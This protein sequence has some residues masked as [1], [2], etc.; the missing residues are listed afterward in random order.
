MQQPYT[1]S[2]VPQSKGS[3]ALQAP[4]VKKKPKV[5]EDPFQQFDNLYSGAGASSTATATSKAMPS[6]PLKFEMPERAEAGSNPF[7]GL[8]GAEGARGTRPPEQQRE[9]QQRTAE[10]LDRG[11]SGGNMAWNDPH[12]P[13]SGWNPRYAPEQAAQ[14]ARREQDHGGLAAPI[15]EK[16]P[17]WEP[18]DPIPSD[19]PSDGP[20]KWRPG[21]PIPPE[22][23]NPPEGGWKHDPDTGYP[24]DQ[25]GKALP[26]P[27]DGW[28]IDSQTGGWVPPNHPN[29]S[30]IDTNIVQPGDGPQVTI[31]APPA[32]VAPEYT[33]PEDYQRRA[34]LAVGE[35]TGGRFDAPGSFEG[36]R[37]DEQAGTEFVAPDA[38]T[39]TGDPGYQFRMK[40]GLRALENS[41]TAQGVARSSNTWKGLL[42]YAGNLASAEYGNVYDRQASEFDRAYGNELEANQINYGR[43]AT[44][45]ERDFGQQL[46]AD[47]TN[48]G[49]DWA[50]HTGNYGIL[51]DQYKTNTGIDQYAHE[52]KTGAAKDKFTADT[53]GARDEYAPTY[54]EWEARTAADQ[55]N[56]ELG[57]GQQWDREKFE[58]DDNYRRWAMDQQIG[59]SD[60]DRQER[61]AHDESQFGRDLAFQREQFR[62]TQE[63]RDKVFASDDQF[64][65]YVNAQD[66][67]WR[68]DVLAEERFKFLANLGLDA[69]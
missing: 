25:Y 67:Q 53:A 32:Y 19:T 5:G 34:D 36:D 54:A 23:Q 14:A 40:E 13:S 12:D 68:R 6:E 16:P 60:R 15:F 22:Y 46:T 50:E 21:E 7:T 28:G 9:R 33:P 43:G 52:S 59:L 64:R 31:N 24:I 42:D 18:G 44:E 26:P 69:S 56:A 17:D 62:T 57:F 4:S 65:R 3:L 11:M 20:P 58:K 55:R 35:F 51:S 41:A 2:T 37:L 29:W 49:R 10:Y 66:E 1:T 30:Y 38:E 27:G 63:F 47:E 48:Y 8:L 45:Q 61:L 39:F